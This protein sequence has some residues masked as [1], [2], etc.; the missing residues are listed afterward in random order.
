MSFLNDVFYADTSGNKL[1]KLTNDGLAV[2]YPVVTGKAPTAVLV[3]SD[4]S[5]VIVT[6]YAANS[7]SFIKDGILQKSIMVGKGP[8]GIC[9]SINGCFY[10]T[11]FVSSTISKVNADGVV[12][13]TIS[14]GRMPKGICCDKEGTI[15]TANYGS[16]SVTKI[17][18]DVVVDTIRVGLNPSGITV[19]KNSMVWVTNTGSH[20]V[21]HIDKINATVVNVQ[22]PNSSPYDICVDLKGA[23]WVTGYASNKV[24]QI[25]GDAVMKSIDVGNKPYTVSCN[26]QNEIYVFNYADS[27]ISKI[28]GDAAIKIPIEGNVIS[29]AY[30]DPTGMDFHYIAKYKENAGGSGSVNPGDIKPGTITYEMLEQTLKDKIDAAK[31]SVIED[32]SIELKKLS[33][34]VQALIKAKVETVPTNSGEAVIS[35]NTISYDKLDAALRAIIDGKMSS[36]APSSITKAMFSTEVINSI[37]EKLSKI[38]NK[39][40]TLDMLAQEVIDKI[41]A[42]GGSGTPAAGSITKDML[43]T[44]LKKTID[45]KLSKIDNGTVTLEMLAQEV[46]DKINAATQSGGGGGGAISPGTITADLLAPSLKILIDSKISKDAPGVIT[47]DM[48]EQTLKD[49]IEAAGGTPAAGS[50]TATMLD[51]AL[52]E[53]IDNKLGK[54]SVGSVTI[55]MLAQEVKAKLDKEVEASGVKYDDATLTTVKKALDKIIADIDNIKANSGGGTVQ[56]PVNISAFTNSVNE[57]EIGSTVTELDLN[58]TVN[59]S[60]AT[61]SIDN[62]V[63]DVT[64]LV[65]KHLTGQSITNDTTYTLSAT[66]KDGHSNDSKTTKIVFLPKIYAGVV[67]S[68]PTDSNGVITLETSK[69]SKDASFKHSFD[70]SAGNKH[71]TIAVPQSYALDVSKFKVGGNANSNWSKTVVNVTNASGHVANYDVFTLNDQQNGSSIEVS[72]EID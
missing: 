15:Y 4:K 29:G 64:G 3:A 10:V 8:I 55:S 47:K 68:A 61:L 36:I 28:V 16:N 41:N 70:C 34:E 25:I 65:T 40:I 37:N 53:T 48:L 24:Y 43:D 57:A 27:F 21:S 23:K 66:A 5:T 2:G 6:N 32:G 1:Y 30:G 69:L 58:W 12:L 11:N 38:E 44:T 63:G 62:G 33:A 60:D 49:K 14:V 17:V 19:D 50:I 51:Q 45:E 59:M 31:P 42:S 54:D 26:D 18:N 13:K 9:E 56:L 7:I 71:I 46:I 72:I 52:K 39:S 35:P 20:S 67:D 22:I